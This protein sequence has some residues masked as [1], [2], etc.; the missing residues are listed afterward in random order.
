[1]KGMVIDVLVR[2]EMPE[3]ASKD[4]LKARAA[5]LNK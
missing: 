3:K 2:T 5:E 1:M 4:E